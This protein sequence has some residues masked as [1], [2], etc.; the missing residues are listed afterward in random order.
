MTV[1]RLLRGLGALAIAAALLGCPAEEGEEAPGSEALTRG[2]ELYQT[3]C[4]VCH[5]ADARGVPG[6]GKNLTT[7]EFVAERSIDEMVAFLKEGR[8]AD[9]PLNTTGVLMPPKAGNPTLTDEQLA[10]IAAFVKSLPPAP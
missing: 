10:D 8:A 6:L 3:N 7:S 2:G 1:R 4:S 5:G 9:H